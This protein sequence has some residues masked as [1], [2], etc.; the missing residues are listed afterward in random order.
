MGLKWTEKCFDKK[1][2]KNLKIFRTNPTYDEIKWL[3]FELEKLG[4]KDEIEW[5]EKYFDKKCTKT[6]KSRANPT[7]D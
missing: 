4:L 1:F 6:V 5:V 3:Q 2:I 7:Y